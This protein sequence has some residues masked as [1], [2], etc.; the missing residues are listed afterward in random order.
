M[1]FTLFYHSTILKENKIFN[2]LLYGSILYLIIHAMMSFIDSE[3]IKII[4]D[5]Y[6]WTIFYLDLGSFMYFNYND[7][8]SRPDS[9]SKI[10]EN[11]KQSD[12]DIKV[13]INTLK[14]KINKILTPEGSLQLSSQEP[15]VTIP[16]NTN[17]TNEIQNEN[18]SFSDNNSNDLINHS[19]QKK[20]KESNFS[21]STPIKKL[22]KQFKPS[23]LDNLPPPKQSQS[24]L[25]PQLQPQ[26]QQSTK[27]ADLKDRLAQQTQSMKPEGITRIGGDTPNINNNFGQSN[28]FD[29]QSVADSDAGS[30]LDLD[31]NDFENSIQ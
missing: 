8:L 23:V 22:H 28:K 27:I 5:N 11:D 24:E 17:P 30:L 29:T 25:Q 7:Y 18:I 3:T 31:L 1:V 16:I 14:N 4:K 26:G 6:F 12:N 20:V 2:S 15:V 19:E 9:N 10:Q 13:S 21:M